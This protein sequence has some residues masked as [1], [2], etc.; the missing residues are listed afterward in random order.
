LSTRLD[1]DPEL[2]L[3]ASAARFRARFERMLELAGTAPDRLTAAQWLE[4]WDAARP[5]VT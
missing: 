2:A 1:V 3:R 5:D 4:L